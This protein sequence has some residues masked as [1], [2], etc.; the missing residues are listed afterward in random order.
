[1]RLFQIF[2]I[3]L[4]LSS[5][6]S[7]QAMISYTTPTVPLYPLE[8]APQKVILLNSYSVQAQ[9]YRDNKE[10]LFIQMIDSLLEESALRIRNT[11]GITAEVISGYTPINRNDT[12]AI[13]KL[14]QQY[15]AGYAFVVTGF[16]V[17]FIQTRV[18][19]TKESS[20]S[21][22][23]EAF[24]DIRA[25]LAFAL[26]RKDG[27][28]RTDDAVRQKY[29]SSRNVAS[30]LLAAGPNI[31]VQ[32]NDAY[33]IVFE[34][35]HDYLNRYFP[36][37]QKH[38]R[39]LFTG[40]GFESTGAA[41]KRGDYEAALIESMKRTRETDDKTMSMANYNCAVLFERKGQREEARKYLQA[42]LQRAALPQAR[43]M[44]LDY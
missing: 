39:P 13:N 25:G 21:K 36:G 34:C 37:Q 16:D 4:L 7:Q 9:K 35:V 20:G 15:G 3:V 41:I 42:S 19:V 44:M 23:R 12:P 17:E 26:L 10:A 11:T 8:P 18:D 14:L 30:G 1:M 32:R 5:C 24:Y 31:V 38:F 33:D 40:K 6:A 27:L 43:A 29:H 2:F 28:V 22:S